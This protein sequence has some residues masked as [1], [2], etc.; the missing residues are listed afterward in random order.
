[1]PQ[2]QAVRLKK[3]IKLKTKSPYQSREQHEVTA[4][5][6]QHFQNSYCVSG[7]ELQ[8]IIAFALQRNMGGKYCL[9]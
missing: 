5:G 4:E 2:P 1:M 3:I 8:C 6:A 7:A 9:F